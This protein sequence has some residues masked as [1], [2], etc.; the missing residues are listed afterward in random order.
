M[1]SGEGV[2]ILSLSSVSGR[3]LGASDTVRMDGGSGISSGN[4]SDPNEMDSSGRGECTSYTGDGM[5][6][7]LS[8]SSPRRPS[9]DNFEVP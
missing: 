2:G 5:P 9:D 3:E 1:K 6:K 7:T 4:R 8:S